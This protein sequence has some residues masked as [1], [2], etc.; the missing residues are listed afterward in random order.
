MKLELKKKEIASKI[1]R[2]KGRESLEKVKGAKN[3]GEKMKKRVLQGIAP[4]T[5]STTT[6]RNSHKI[7][8][9]KMRTWTPTKTNGMST[10]TKS[11]NPIARSQRRTRRRLKK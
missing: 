10:M 9:K 6:T 1:K 2:Q 5:T 11:I 3:L 8:T 7:S 4:V